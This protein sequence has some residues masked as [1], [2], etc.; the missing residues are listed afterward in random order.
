MAFS[1][2]FTEMRF[3]TIANKYINACIELFVCFSA[4]KNL[5]N[6]AP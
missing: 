5:S 6:A 1:K 3:G 4:A 2:C